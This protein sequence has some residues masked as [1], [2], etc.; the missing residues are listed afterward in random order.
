V[1]K[2]ADYL[3]D[4]GPEAADKGGR[5]VAKGAPEEVAAT[6]ES[7]TGAF[8]AQ[9]FEADRLARLELDKYQSEEETEE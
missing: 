5:V 6:A 7:I 1:M 3:I 2:A 9:A 4:L 8:L